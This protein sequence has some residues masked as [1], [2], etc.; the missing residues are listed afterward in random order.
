MPEPIVPPP[1]TATFLMVMSHLLV[2]VEGY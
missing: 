1:I 2:P